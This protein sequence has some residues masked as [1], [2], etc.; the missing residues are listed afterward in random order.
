LLA[1]RY[2]FEDTLASGATCDD[3]PRRAGTRGLSLVEGILAADR[4]FYVVHGTGI[5]HQITARLRDDV[6]PLVLDKARH[7]FLQADAL[8]LRKLFGFN[9]SYPETDS[10]HPAA[11]P[12]LLA[13]KMRQQP[14]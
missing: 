8:P 10:M 5:V 4:G 1:A 9:M 3:D 12:S 11:L 13:F 7:V 2:Q 14:F 6:G